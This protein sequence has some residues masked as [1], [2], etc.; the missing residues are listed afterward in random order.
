MSKSWFAFSFLAVFILIIVLRF[1]RLGSIPP[2]LTKDEAFYGYDA[3]SILKTGRDI[4]GYKLPLLFKSTGE[5]KLNLTYLMVPGI[6][7]FGLS[8][9]TVRLPS[10]IFGLATLLVL[11]FTLNHLFTGRPFALIMTAVFALSPWSFGMSRLFYESNVGL[12]F[13][14]LGLYFIFTRRFVY[15]AI[16]LALSAYLYNSYRYVGL[17]LLLSALIL[18]RNKLINFLKP[19]LLYIV[20]LLP[21]LLSGSPGIVTKRLTQELALRRSSYEM[22]VNNRRAECYLHLG[23]NP[24]LAKLCY[25]L[26]NKPILYLTDVSSILVRVLSPEF[27]FMQAGNQYSVP[28]GYGVYLSYLFPFYLLG[29]AWLIGIPKSGRSDW[30]NRLVLLIGI[31][32]SG[33]VASSSG[34]LESYRYPAMLYFIFLIIAAGLRVGEHLWL[35]TTKLLPVFFL[36]LFL[37]IGSF[38]TV[39]YLSTY[40]LYSYSLPLLFSS[41]VREIYQFLANKRDY[42]YLVDKK[43]FGPLTAA[44]F[45]Q[46]DPAYFREHLVWTDPDP[47][48]FVNIAR[49]DNLYSQTYTIDSLLCLK[50]QHPEL[51]LKALV[52][53]DP[54]IYAQFADFSTTDYSG[55]L[56]LHSVYDIDELYPKV[57]KFYPGNLCQK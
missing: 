16:P 48:G 53:D 14:S 36:T 23:H 44:F 54:G 12:F 40:Y 1:W 51:P 42:R 24:G 43:Y 50:H 18:Y 15:S 9:M 7:Y 25:P 8:E 37:I 45:W 11:Y 31:L 6:K 10:A 29:I 26:W 21:I 28:E 57:L 41:D 22:V 2:G 3:Y 13:I 47:W 56:T 30:R 52:I 32:V 39:K 38:Q 20:L 34:S 46:I 4:W 17:A 33:A 5:Y 19:L 27:L 49:M 35:K 55:T